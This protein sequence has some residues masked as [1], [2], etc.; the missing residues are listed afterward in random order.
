M[1]PM[2]G[3]SGMP[4]ALAQVAAV[5]GQ[6]GQDQGDPAVALGQ[7]PG[8]QGPLITGRPRRSA[9]LRAGRTQRKQVVEQSG[10]TRPM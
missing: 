10:R 7:R 1:A 6:V 2:A 8:A 5:D 4:R 9:A 3:P